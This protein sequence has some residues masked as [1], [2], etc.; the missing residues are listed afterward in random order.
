MSSNDPRGGDGLTEHE[1]RPESLMAEQRTAAVTDVGRMLSRYAE[2]VLVACPA[3]ESESACPQFE[4][5]SIRY[6]TCT[7]CATSYV[8]P[9]PTREV[10][11]WFYRGSP[12]YSYWNNVVF[13][14]SEAVRTRKIFVPRVDHLLELCGRYSVSTDSLLEVGAGFG[15]FCAEVRSRHVFS[16]VIAVEPTPDL[17]STCRKRGLEVLEMPVEQLPA[18]FSGSI[19][20]V[21]SFEV[22]E[23]LFAPVEFLQRVALL[24]KPGGILVLTCPNGHGFDI[25]T[26][27]AAS[28]TVD[29]EHLNYFNADSLKRLVRRCGLSVLE[30]FTPGQLDAE[31]VRNKILAKEFDISAQ[32]FLQKVLIDDWERLGAPFQQ[33]LVTHRLSSNMWLVAQRPA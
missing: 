7:E 19:D 17:A 29:H 9:R 6:V 26:L 18:A 22:I 10:L 21:A 32:P 25:R 27:G 14:A 28:N 15:T 2:F 12:N 4:K 20:V 33:F 24:L 30:S 11:E 8:S 3:C 16:R 13:P 23:H 31:L 1:I 5:N